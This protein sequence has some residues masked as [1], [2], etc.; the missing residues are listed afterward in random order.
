MRVIHVWEMLTLLREVA[1]SD[2][3]FV[4]PDVF[5]WRSPLVKNYGGPVC[6]YARADGSGPACIVGHVLDRLGLLGEAV[7]NTTAEECL[8]GVSGVLFTPAALVVA[9]LAQEAQDKGLTWAK[10]VDFAEARIRYRWA[11]D[12]VSE[13]Q[14]A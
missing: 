8:S 6:L 3:D 1:D 9:D 14:P 13:P 4:Y 10:A 2:P 12:E 11:S 7:E 5:P